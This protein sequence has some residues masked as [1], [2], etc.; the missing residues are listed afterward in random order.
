MTRRRTRRLAKVA[1]RAR[2]RRSDKPPV[3]KPGLRAWLAGKK[4]IRVN[5]FAGGGG[6]SQGER[7]ATG[8][9]P[10]IAV[11]HW[12]R[13][14]EMHKI[15]H[16]TT[17]HYQEDV[18]QVDPR[19]ATEGRTVELLWM[20]PTCIHF[21]RAKGHRLLDA[22]IRSQANVVFT[23]ITHADVERII[24]ENVIEFLGWGPLHKDHSGGCTGDH[25]MGK[26]KEPGCLKK[27]RHLTP[28]KERKGEYFNHFVRKLR[29]KG[30]NVGWQTLRAHLYGAPTRRARLFLVADRTGEP[31]FPAPTHGPGLIPFRVTHENLDFELPVRSIFGRKKAP[32]DATL[33]RIGRGVGEYVIK[34]ARPFVISVNHGGDSSGDR[35][36]RLHDLTEPLPVVTSGGGQFALC[37][38]SM[39][40][41]SNGE[42]PG[43]LPRIYD[44]QQPHPTAVSG[45]I[46]TALIETVLA[47]VITKHYG[48]NESSTGGQSVERE[49]DTITAQDHNALTIASM[50]KLRGTSDAHVNASAKSVE[51]PLDV[52]SAGGTH[53]ALTVATIVRYN[54]QRRDGEAPRQVG[55]E[56]P[57]PTQDTSNRFSLTTAN[58]IRYNGQ[59]GPQPVTDSLGTIDTRDRFAL[60]QT[61][62]GSV[63]TPLAA[64]VYRFLVQHVVDLPYVEVE[65]VRYAIAEV[66]GQIYVITDIGM[67]MLTPV[68]LFKCQGFPDS[69]VL[70]FVTGKGKRVTKTELIRLCGNSVCPP[71]AE[72]MV[73]ATLAPRATRLAA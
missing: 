24:L 22:K 1:K 67:R 6:A 32:A 37:V 60:I 65:S 28:I 17:K 30:F 9:S 5:L 62:V 42:R 26:G 18:F 13:A 69:Y 36:R 11:N 68:E 41:C 57:L 72:A 52:V 3:R 50:I 16:P 59:S 53:H 66:D 46:K 12:D 10:D 8:T 48:G 34:A 43:Q 56:Q 19:E 4:K 31:R 58:L 20:S 29:R 47:P 27:C 39:I 25:E 35:F 63:L 49:L 23:W 71:V 70:D 7:D 38:P 51:E 33:R 55:L 45:G 2:G 64:E 73:R 40:H 54:G 44:V 61:E 15:N 14:I 21:S